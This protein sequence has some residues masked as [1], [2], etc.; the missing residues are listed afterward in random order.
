MAAVEV[1]AEREEEVVVVVMGA[2]RKQI[3]NVA[4][5][6]QRG[7]CRDSSGNNREEEENEEEEALA[8]AEVAV[9][10]EV[11]GEV[12]CGGDDCRVYEG[13]GGGG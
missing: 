9:W 2:K 11:V 4:R 1:A 3:K 5:L 8:V 6:K 12:G 7:D 10:E 13:S